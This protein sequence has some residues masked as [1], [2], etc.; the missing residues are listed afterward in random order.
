MNRLRFPHL[1]A[2]IAI[3]TISLACGYGCAFGQT[4]QRK[5]PSAE[6]VVDNYL[7]AIGGKKAVAGI[8]DTTYDFSIQFND[9]LFGT[10]RVQ[11]KTP[12]SERWEMTFGN[13]QIISA[14]NSGSAWERGLNGQLRTL[15][16]AEAAAAKLRGILNA[17]RLVNIKKSNVLARVLSV[18]DLGSEPAYI[19]EFSTRSGARLQYYF[20]VKSGLIT[21]ITDDVRKT[22]IFFEDYKRSKT[23]LEPHRIRLNLDSGELALHLQSASYDTAVAGA[24]F[25]PPAATET[26]DVVSLLREV[27][28]N[29]DELEQRVSEYAFRQ[30][31]TDREITDKGV[32]K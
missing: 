2:T 28:R 27:G 9:Q 15:T 20:S 8:R 32:I 11:T 16:G 7:K 19:V 1:L 22:R 10:A 31:E 21:K 13:G 18:G 5:L 17:S 30:K 12:G 6:K 24:I 29:Q 3:F 23:I 14:T 26:L 4:T 25:D